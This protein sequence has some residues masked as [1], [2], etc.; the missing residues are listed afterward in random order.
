MRNRIAFA[1][2]VGPCWEVLQIIRS[3][4]QIMSLKTESMHR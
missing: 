2:Y 3:N 4:S 1:L